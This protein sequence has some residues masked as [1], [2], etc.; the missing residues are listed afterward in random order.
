MFKDKETLEKLNFI[1]FIFSLLLIISII[2][3]FVLFY[4]LSNPILI[5]LSIFYFLIIIFLSYQLIKLRKKYLEGKLPKDFISDTKY[6]KLKFFMSILLLI[7]L[8]GPIL[9]SL[10]KIKS[11]AIVVIGIY[12][13]IITP[14]GLII[15]ILLFPSLIESKNKD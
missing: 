14:P 15:L 5:I 12:F 4:K 1:T 11:P 3:M 10:F 9:I 8:I 13:F 2:V 6:K 7:Y